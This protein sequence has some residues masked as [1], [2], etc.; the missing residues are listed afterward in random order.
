MKIDSTWPVCSGLVGMPKQ[1]DLG[2]VRRH[3]AGLGQS[4]LKTWPRHFSW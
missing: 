4:S 1:K 3:Q 2:H